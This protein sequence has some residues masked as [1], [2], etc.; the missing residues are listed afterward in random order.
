MSKLTRAF[1]GGGSQ[2][3]IW[4]NDRQ[5]ACHRVNLRGSAVSVQRQRRLWLALRLPPSMSPV[6]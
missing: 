2:L 5:A 3:V 6:T 1:V 4:I